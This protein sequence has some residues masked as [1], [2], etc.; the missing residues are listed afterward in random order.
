MVLIDFKRIQLRSLFFGVLL[1]VC[2]VEQYFVWS[3]Y[4]QNQDTQSVNANFAFLL[5]GIFTVLYAWFAF[6]KAKGITD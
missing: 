6:R 4:L 1:T 5:T 2:G 3:S